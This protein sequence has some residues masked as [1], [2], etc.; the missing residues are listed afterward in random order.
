MCVIT[1]SANNAIVYQIETFCFKLN[2]FQYLTLTA[3]TKRV[4]MWRA[5]DLN[6]NE[7]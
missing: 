7:P 1:I 5:D 4:K 2:Y 6:D 3:T